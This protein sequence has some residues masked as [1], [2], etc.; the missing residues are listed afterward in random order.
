MIAL[1]M[2]DST[3]RAQRARRPALALWCCVLL[4][5]VAPALRGQASPPFT[6]PG[7]YL[8]RADLDFMRKQV[9]GKAEPWLT[10]YHTLRMTT[11]ED[12]EP[13]PLT[14]LIFK[15]PRDATDEQRAK[16]NRREEIKAAARLSLSHALLWTVT[17]ESRHAEKAIRIFEQLARGLWTFDDNG[18]K[19]MAAQHCL[20]LANA[21]EILRYTY[22]GW[23][24]EHT[25]TVNRI[26]MGSIYPVLRFYYPEANGNWDAAISQALMSIAV[27]T[28]NRSLFDNA[29]QHFLYGPANGGVFKYVYPSGQ[30]QEATRDQSHS[31]MGLTLAA[32][33]ARIAYVQGMDLFALGDHRLAL[34]FEYLSRYLLGEEPHAYG[35][36]SPKGREKL[37]DDYHFVLY[38]H[39]TAGVA[40]PHTEKLFRR[41]IERFQGTATAVATAAPWTS[42]QYMESVDGRRVEVDAAAILMSMRAHQAG[43]A[44]APSR[45]VSPSPIAHAAGAAASRLAPPAADAIRVQPGESLQEAVDK[46]A[47]SGRMV[48]A[49]AGVHPLKTTLLIPSNITLRGEGRSTILLGGVGSGFSAIEAKDRRLTNVALADFVLEGAREVSADPANGSRFSRTGKFSNEMNGINF[50]GDFEGAFNAI[51]L[52]NVSVNN[53]SRNGVIISGTR[54]LVIEGCDLS[55]NGSYVVPGPRL[56]HNLRLV[57]V[58]QASIKD[59]RLDTSLKGA[60]V[61]VE[62]SSDVAISSCEIARNGWYGIIIAEC[63][64]LKIENCL[65]EASDNS[66]ICLSFL[67]RGSRHVS[68]TGNRIQY[69]RGHG[70]ESYRTAELRTDGNTY[71]L[72]ARPGAPEFISDQPTLILDDLLGPR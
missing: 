20:C 29:I 59:C 58:Q 10:A 25:E 11:P 53:F 42:A 13:K 24:E 45:K 63:E 46:A 32:Q 66:G 48:V 40:M 22:P 56:T 2:N 4:A 9:R 21:A 6:H 30:C 12:F 34:G 7:I 17:G 47:V 31:Q 39:R 52:T 61:M 23:R 38:H 37:K 44:P 64:R 28:D 27:F 55:D 49:V 50:A 54:N 19:L 8:T 62:F 15:T 70:L 68:V 3:P 43:P 57:H 1:K 51:T 33:T 41:L 60:G 72:N 71:D 69:N 67:L 36:I 14:H 35:T 16:L 26:L 18:A 5:G 65:I